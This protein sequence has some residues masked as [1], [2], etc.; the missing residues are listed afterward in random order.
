MDEAGAAALV[1]AVVAAVLAPPIFAS[2]SKP[3]PRVIGVTFVQKTEALDESTLAPRQ[4]SRGSQPA[5]AAVTIR[6]PYNVTAPGDT[7]SRQRIF[8]CRPADTAAEPACARQ[9]LSTLARR[10]YRRPV[11]EADVATLLTFYE[12]GRKERDFDFGIQ[13]ASNACW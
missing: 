1:A 5:V 11:T 7:P 2:R 12:A 8:T 3:G 13:R 4:R 9:I 10:A 6:G